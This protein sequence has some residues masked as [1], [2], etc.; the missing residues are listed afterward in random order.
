M[1]N[2]NSWQEYQTTAMD[3]SDGL[4]DSLT[5]QWMIENNRLFQWMIGMY[6]AQRG[7]MV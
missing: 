7:A 1:D 3:D 4:Q 6:G 5:V 2:K